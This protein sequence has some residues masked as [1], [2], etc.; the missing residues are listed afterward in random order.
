MTPSRRGLP[1]LNAMRAF[2]VAGRRLTFHAAADELGVT[3]GAVAQQVRALEEHLGLTLFRRLPRGL[4]LTPQGTAYLAELTRAF[5]LL[6]EATG[7]LYDAPAAVTIS[8][9]PT[10]AAKLLIPRLAALNA[11]LPEVELRT[12]ATE[13]ISDFDRDQVDMAVRLTRPPFPAAQEAKLLFRQELVAVANPL[14][15]KGLSLPLTAKQLAGLPLLHDA[16]NHWPAWLQTGKTLPGAVF[17]QT[18]LALDAAMAGQ[19][20]ALVCRAF[21]AADLAA[22]RLVQV[23]EESRGT[24]SDYFLVRKRSPSHGKAA[25]AVWDWC[26]NRFG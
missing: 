17:S 26:L 15:V 23:T 19:G 7:R 16:H 6:A 8:V 2:E 9:T 5:D 24:D 10:F 3:Q 4:A 20:V 21:V 1:P 11:A 22:G 12:I 13:T 14:L 18:T 25:E